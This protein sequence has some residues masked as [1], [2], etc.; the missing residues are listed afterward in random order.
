M[1]I[2]HYE[3]VRTQVRDDTSPTGLRQQ[4][5]HRRSSTCTLGFTRPVLDEAGN[6]A[7]VPVKDERGKPVKDEVTGATLV[8]PEVK[9]ES[10]TRGDDGL[11]EVPEDV[12]LYF[13]HGTHGQGFP[14]WTVWTG[15]ALDPRD[16]EL[17]E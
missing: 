11:F 12:G 1:K 10:Y 8:E 2:A 3:T 17:S 6:Q 15:E 7:L 4:T 16:E 13:T 9:R 5:I 14:G